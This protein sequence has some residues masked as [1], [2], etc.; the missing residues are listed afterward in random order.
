RLTYIKTPKLVK[1]IVK[2]IIICS[3]TIFLVLSLFLTYALPVFKLPKTTGQHEVGV[4]YIHLVDKTRNDPF[5]KKGTQKRELMVKVYYPAKKDETKPYSIYFQSSKFVKLFSKFY[6]MPEFVFQQLN[7]V[8]TNSKE[9]LQVSDKEQNYPVILF[10]HGAGTT[11]EVHTSQSEDL[12]SNGYIV[13]AIEHTFV[14]SGTVFPKKVV[15][16]MDATKEFDTPEPARIITQIMAE[17]SKFVIDSLSKINEGKI[18]STFKGKLNINEIGTV[19]HSVGGA[20]AYNLAINDKR[21][22]AAIDLDGV[23][24]ITPKKDSSNMAPFLMLAND[25]YHV[26]AIQNH[27]PLMPNYEDLKGIDKDIALSNYGSEKNYNENYKF[28]SKGKK[29]ESRHC[30]RKWL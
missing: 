15:S 21:I 20:V 3:S 28:K 9:D 18:V 24:Y 13:V 1:K 19:G 2:I 5:L 4:K 11:M 30:R 22:K 29:D 10:S 16:Q 27:E 23:V 12:A 17:D 25:K 6:H 8:K 26:Q 14:S 7:L